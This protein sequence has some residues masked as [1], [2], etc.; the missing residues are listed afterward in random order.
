MRIFDPHVHC[1][2]RVTDD[3]ERMY[4]AGIRVVLEP[5][6]WLGQARTSVGTFIDYFDTLLG[7]ERHRAGGFGIHHVCTMALNPRE[8]NDDRV[9]DGHS[10]TANEYLG[11][12]NNALQDP[13]YAIVSGDPSA[14][15]QLNKLVSDYA[16]KHGELLPIEDALG[17]VKTAQVERL[18][19]LQA[20]DA[21]AAEFGEIQSKPQ[22][23]P[24]KVPP[25]VSNDPPP[26]ATPPA[27]ADGERLPPRE[28]RQ[29]AVDAVVASLGEG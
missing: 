27:D 29:R 16:Q 28:L 10:R 19:K 9:N 12:L 22:P 1:I 4:E 15:H 23:A 25:I 2:S 21:W 3:Y 6:F 7:W 20:T 13:Q 8:A 26:R 17:R 14:V 5:A 24:P 11:R 18:R